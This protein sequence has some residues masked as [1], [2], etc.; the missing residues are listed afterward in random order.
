MDSS[1]FPLA[2]F[3]QP[4]SLFFLVVACVR[5][6]SAMF[7]VLG[8]GADS[9]IRACLGIWGPIYTILKQLRLIFARQP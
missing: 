6:L 1:S 5:D 3:H 4:F 2:S 9:S 8:L 7:R